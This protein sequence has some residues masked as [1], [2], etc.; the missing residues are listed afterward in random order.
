MIL[1]ENTQ[2]SYEKSTEKLREL[3]KEKFSN[4]TFQ[5]LIDLNLRPLVTGLARVEQA[6]ERK[7][8]AGLNVDK[9]GF[10]TYVQNGLNKVIQRNKNKI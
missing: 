4:E 1:A 9:N 10:E 5:Q 8:T 7:P 6:I 2:R 3:S